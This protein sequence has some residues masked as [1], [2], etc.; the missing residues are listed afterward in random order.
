MQ[1]EAS[2]QP[3]QTPKK[4]MKANVPPTVEELTQRLRE[5][6]RKGHKKKGKHTLSKASL[7]PSNTATNSSR[8]RARPSPKVHR[9]ASTGDPATTASLAVVDVAPLEHSGE[10]AIAS[11]VRTART[12]ANETKVTRQQ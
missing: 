5:S 12:T 1:E 10:I 4:R 2:A 11:T 8:S 3:S 6:K 9:P 7:Y